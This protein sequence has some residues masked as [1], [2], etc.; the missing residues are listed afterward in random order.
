MNS[1]TLPEIKNQPV[2]A[3]QNPPPPLPILDGFGR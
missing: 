3:D 2:I 1:E